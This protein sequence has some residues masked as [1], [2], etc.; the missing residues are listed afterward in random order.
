MK[1]KQTLYISS[2]YIDDDCNNVLRTMKELGVFC[3]ISPTKSIVKCSSKNG[4]C[5][6]ENGCKIILNRTKTEDVNKNVW[7]PLKN[8]YQLGCA[9]IKTNDY[10]GCINR[11]FK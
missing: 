8:Y 6:T 11:Y 9:Y 4:T 10:K 7:S 2:R 5:V 1:D 3:N